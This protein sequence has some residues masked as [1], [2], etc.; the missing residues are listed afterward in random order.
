VSDGQH[1]LAVHGAA[2]I[3][4]NGKALRVVGRGHHLYLEVERLQDFLEAGKSPGG[5]KGGALQT[6]RRIALALREAGLTL[7]LVSGG[8]ELVI[9]GRDARPTLL[10]RLHGIPHLQVKDGLELVRSVL[11]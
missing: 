6:V 4:F 7:S 9:V 11:F 8:K 10:D 2:K 5:G 1:G 3:R